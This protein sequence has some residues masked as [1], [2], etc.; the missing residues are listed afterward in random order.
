[1]YLCEKQESFVAQIHI[2]FHIR[3]AA[4]NHPINCVKAI[5]HL[6]LFA[7]LKNETFLYKP[8]SLKSIKNV[9]F[10]NVFP[11]SISK[12]FIPLSTF[13]EL[14]SIYW[15]KGKIDMTHYLIN[16]TYFTRK[17]QSGQSRTLAGNE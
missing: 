5:K 1:M 4:N 9:S 10:G 11:K 14:F 17:I 12:T 2:D 7:F 6:I 3:S 13:C 15:A 16:Y 8:F